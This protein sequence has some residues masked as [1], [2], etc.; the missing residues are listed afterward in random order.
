MSRFENKL[1]FYS[2]LKILIL[3]A[4]IF[5]QWQ[6][7]MLDSFSKTLFS[8]ATKTQHHLCSLSRS[9]HLSSISPGT[10]SL[11]CFVSNKSLIG[12]VSQLPNA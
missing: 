10:P 7:N 3:I 11:L 1:Q 6:E 12:N 8:A 9:R 2:H 5:Q 4:A